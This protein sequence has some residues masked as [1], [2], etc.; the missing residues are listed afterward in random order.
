[1]RAKEKLS[2]LE[3]QKYDDIISPKTVTILENKIAS[4]PMKPSA[5]QAAFDALDL[6]DLTPKAALDALYQLKRLR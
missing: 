5:W 1:M 3:T 6:D 2:Q 4:E